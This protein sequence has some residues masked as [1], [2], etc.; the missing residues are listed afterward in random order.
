[1]RYVLGIDIGSY[2]SKGVLL[3][4]DG[5]ILATVQRKHQMGIPGPGRAEHDA[6]SD[7][8]EGFIELAQ[9]LLAQ[10]GINPA[11]IA[12]VGCSGI[13][14]CVLPVDDAGRPLRKAIL[15]GVDTRA[16]AEIAELNTLLGEETV[17]ARCGNALTTQSVGPKIRWLAKNEPEVYRKTDKIVGCSS[18]LIYQLTGR[19]VI[20]H[21]SASCYTPCYDL[22]N[23]R[24]NDEMTRRICPPEWLP[25]IIWSSE[26]AGHISLAAAKITG[27]TAGTPVI[28]GTIDS[29]SE[30]VSVG[31]QNAG[32]VMVMYG[33]TAFFIQVKQ[34]LDIDA[35]YWSAPYVFPHT[36]SA[37]GGLA[38]GGAITQWLVQGIIRP[39]QEADA[40]ALLTQEAMQ[41]P[42]GANGLLVLPYFSG[43]RTPINDP[44]AKGMFFGLTLA[45]T[46]GDL[47]R[48]VLEGIGHAV[49][50]N[51]DTFAEKEAAKTLYA[52][53]G[54]VKNP[55][56]MQAVCDIANVEQQVRQY[57]VGAA[58]G[59]AFLAGIGAN[60]F[61]RRDIDRINPLSH[62]LKPQDAN[63]AVYERDHQ[64]YLSL[65]QRTKDI[66]ARL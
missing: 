1:M 36:W 16:Q 2:S 58:L 21:Y 47:F 55:V 52:V 4:S 9:R 18:Y 45:H 7:W 62:C 14:P 64:L 31:V 29:A 50:H 24:W 25:E 59:S 46:R 30:A 51:L 60:I 35:R 3:D 49:R 22:A 17:L 26:I 40:F 37:M 38:T 19:W 39:P 53:G 11:D 5:R 66:M 61:T 12:A 15:Y 43:E 41:S 42:A 10:T 34:Q 32:D 65:Y 8:W 28:A 13:G 27:L 48:A 20:D 63:K 56:W 44:N 57:T 54:G 23:G 6:Q 33:T